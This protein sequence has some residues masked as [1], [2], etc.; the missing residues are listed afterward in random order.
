MSKENFNFD[1]VSFDDL[2]TDDMDI[3]KFQDDGELNLDM[4][5]LNDHN[6]IPASVP[7]NPRNQEK[8]AANIE[9]II[10]NLLENKDRNTLLLLTGDR[11]DF[12]TNLDSKLHQD[13]ASEYVQA[14]MYNP[15]IKWYSKL[16]NILPEEQFGVKDGCLRITMP[17]A[18]FE[19]VI[20][21]F[22]GDFDKKFSEDSPIV[23][24]VCDCHEKHFQ[25]EMLKMQKHNDQE[26]KHLDDDADFMNVEDS[27]VEELWDTDDVQHA[28]NV[29]VDDNNSLN[30]GEIREVQA[31]SLRLSDLS[32]KAIAS[33]L[34]DHKLVG[35]EASERLESEIQD[36]ARRNEIAVIMGY[37]QTQNQGPMQHL[38]PMARLR[39]NP[40]KDDFGWDKE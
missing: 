5:E 38:R 7:I 19:K 23:K 25:N 10:L 16:A 22:M 2:D 26:G 24:L 27:E 39:T 20:L 18:T 32:N 35:H 30:Q 14:C 11:M 36:K 33:Y 40:N 17:K 15:A 37:M 21:P 13:F 34:I 31:K 3:S 6:D 4:S 9:E 28:G 1:V 12:S 29:R 8:I